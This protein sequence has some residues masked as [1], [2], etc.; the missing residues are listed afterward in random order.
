[1]HEYSLMERV[2]EVIEKRVAQQDFDPAAIREVSL[3]VGMMELHS[4]EA[5]EQAF[6]VQ[7]AD[8]P[9]R[10]AV[11]RLEVIP[12]QIECSHC[13]HRGDLVLGQADPHDPYPIA[14]CPQC[15]QT[16]PVQGGH[17]VASIELDL[18]ESSP[19]RCQAGDHDRQPDPSA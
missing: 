16:C 9:Y 6:K 5:F 18:E 11:L 14:E 19:C 8:K 3:K 15:G 1:M 4:T 10:R 7:I 17:G 12:A 13:G 2:I